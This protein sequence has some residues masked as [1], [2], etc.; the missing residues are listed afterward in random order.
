MHPSSFIVLLA[1][2][3]CALAACTPQQIYD[4]V[5]LWG[6]NGWD[7]TIVK[8]DNTHQFNGKPSVCWTA[9]NYA[10]ICAF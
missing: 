4:G 7:P 3:A 5:Y 6:D 8:Q 1:M 2:V 10:G 9:S